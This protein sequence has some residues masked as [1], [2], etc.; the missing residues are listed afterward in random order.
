MHAPALELRE[1]GTVSST[2]CQRRVF[3]FETI[4]ITVHHWCERA[5]DGDEVGARVEIQR[6]EER[7]GDHEFHAWEFL[8]HDPLFRADLFRISTGTPG[9]FDRAHYHPRFDG[10]VAGGRVFEPELTA[11]PLSWLAGRLSDLPGLLEKAGRPELVYEP[12]VRRVREAVPAIIAVVRDYLDVLP[13]AE[14]VSGSAAA[15]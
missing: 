13:E 2:G 12:D 9:N 6:L 8:L 10:R 3:L 14:P 7:P 5:A 11:D 1:V 4:G 15:R